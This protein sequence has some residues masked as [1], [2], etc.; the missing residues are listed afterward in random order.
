MIKGIFKM[1]RLTAKDLKSGIV[2]FLTWNYRMA[3][4]KTAGGV[5]IAYPLRI[6]GRGTLSVG[7]GASIGRK[8]RIGI[9][10]NAKIE[11][12]QRVVIHPDTTVFAADSATIKLE[13]NTSILKGSILR[14]G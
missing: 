7:N 10:K 6:E 12:G 11:L 1:F 5:S 14:N 8:V 4:V 13:D 2:K 9:A 3:S